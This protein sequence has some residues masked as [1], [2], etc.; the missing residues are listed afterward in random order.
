MTCPLT[1]KGGSHNALSHGRPLRVPTPPPAP[2]ASSGGRMCTTR[3]SVG[4][5][6]GAFGDPCRG[7]GGG[8]PV[9]CFA[10]TDQLWKGICLDVTCM[11]VC[12]R[13]CVRACVHAHPVCRH[14]HRMSRA[15]LRAADGQTH[16]DTN[17][18]PWCLLSSGKACYKPVA[19]HNF[20][21]AAPSRVY[22]VLPKLVVT[23]VCLPTSRQG[24][25]SGLCLCVLEAVGGGQG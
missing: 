21:W 4:S 18:H 5:E 2:N 10:I 12:V 22:W 19:F 8:R 14:S 15:C 20:L 9:Q 6:A 3:G 24:Q 1:P 11:C 7:G 13:V 17:P 25:W 23:C 16:D